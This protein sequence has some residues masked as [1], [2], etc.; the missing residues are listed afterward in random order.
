MPPAPK[1]TRVLTAILCMIL[2]WAG[3][4]NGS[5]AED[6]GTSSSAAMAATYRV[7]IGEMKQADRGPFSRI[8][9]FCRDGTIRDAKSPC[10]NNGGGAQHGEWTD[11]V[12][13]MRRNGYRI[14]NIYE[15]LDIAATLRQSDFQDIYN[16]MLFEQFLIAHD[17]GWILRKARYY[18]G[19]LQ[20]EGDIEGARNLL[21]AMMRDPLWVEQRFLPLRLGARLLPHGVTEKSIVEV[22][23]LS[24]ALA[25][26]DPGFINI[27][28]K[29]HGRPEAGDAVLVREYAR[30]V[31]REDLAADMEKLAARID[32]LF[33]TSNLLRPALEALLRRVQGSQDMRDAIRQSMD[34]LE[35]AVAPA[36]RYAATARALARLRDLWPRFERPESR[37][38][39]LNASLLLEDEHF[40]RAAALDQLL[41]T[42]TRRQQL[43]WL[44]LSAEA[45]YGAG[46]ISPR[47]RAAVRERLAALPESSTSL[48]AY[49][50]RLDYAALV[51]GWAAQQLRFH[52]Q[53]SQEKFVAIEPLVDLFPQSVLRGSPLFFYAHVVDSLLRDANRLAGV[54][55][56]LFGSDVGGGLRALNAGLARGI[57]HIVEGNG[58]G[59]SYSADGIYL[60]P[61]TVADLPPV[62]GI[63]TRGEGNPLSH[64]QILARNL[65]IPNVAVD[66]SLVTQLRARDGQR[67]ILAVSRGGGVQ[68]TGDDGEAAALFAQENRAPEVVIRVDLDKL[69]LGKQDFVPLERLRAS[70]SGRLVGPKAAKLGELKLHYPEAVADGIAIPFGA[71]RKVLDQPMPGAGRSA[72]AWMTAEYHR[73]AAITDT[74]D[75]ARQTEE[76]RQRLE[77]W[78]LNVDPGPEFR[79]G[80]RKVMERT[81]GKDGTYGV[82]VRSDT[83][84]EDLAGFT[85]AG[86]NLTLPN[87]VGFEEVMKALARVWAS[88]FSARSFAWRQTRMDKP[89]HTYPAVLLLK[90]VP[91]EKSGVM[92]TQ[93][94][95]TGAAG[96]LSVAVNEGVGGAVDGQAAESLR[97]DTVTGEVTL[98]AQA[99]ATT[100]R[101]LPANGGIEKVPVSGDD[102][103]L[104]PHEITQLIR[105]ARELPTRFPPIVDADGRPA[106]ADIEFGFLGGRLQLFQIRPFLESAK[107]RSSEYL[108]NL[109]ASLSDA[110]R[111]V[112]QLDQAPGR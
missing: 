66:E 26:R 62:A 32:N 3:V 92:V 95:D 97:I 23:D 34:E 44:A 20:A 29:I 71:F 58:A 102:A 31:T 110:A 105:L 67:V 85:G 111:T 4:R 75:R 51:P 10:T 38:A 48:A 90:S 84:V 108:R 9:W 79:S 109:D 65:G 47:E 82:F 80:L 33:S 103:V 50:A 78:V 30:G 19:A 68:V 8:R 21:I 12:K 49:K 53:A 43:D 27:R 61:E 18:R 13:E 6:S 14:A 45:T 15:D 98:L 17:D 81:F 77:Q 89:E 88:P 57:L 7:W 64:I 22:R 87:V 5:A 73:L 96:A 86:L 35:R 91:N 101:I 74:A 83:N 104:K 42:A 69:D 54:K 40:A 25:G 52:F 76:F 63:L 106:P 100:R 70:D 2:S 39:L 93:D 99:T 59:V 11:H 1:K 24:A 56:D 107:A 16:Q 112:V 46:L 72:F 37:H 36:D 60:L 94:I 41:D 55:R 28:N